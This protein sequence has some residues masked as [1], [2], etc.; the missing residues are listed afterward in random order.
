[1]TSARGALASGSRGSLFFFFSIFFFRS[2]PPTILDPPETKRKKKNS[3]FGHD[4]HLLL[5]TFLAED[6]ASRK[7]DH[8]R[9]NGVHIKVGA[10]RGVSDGRRGRSKGAL[11]SWVK[12]QQQINRFRMRSGFRGNS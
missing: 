6:N 8:G 5:Q 9:A 2:L 1:M 7:N 10:R 3:P 4:N 12:E 11:L